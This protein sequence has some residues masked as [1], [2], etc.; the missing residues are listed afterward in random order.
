[1]INHFY[2]LPKAIKLLEAAGGHIV[3][4]TRRRSRPVIMAEHQRP[5]IGIKITVT[6][7]GK[8]QELYASRVHGCQVFLTKQDNH[9]VD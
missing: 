5:E 2:A 6:N 3:S 4:T 7:H 1:M 8:T 9:Y